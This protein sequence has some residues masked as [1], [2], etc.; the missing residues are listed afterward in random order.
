MSLHPAILIL[1]VLCANIPLESGQWKAEHETYLVEHVRT[2]KCP[3]CWGNTRHVFRVTDRGKNET[4]HLELDWALQELNGLRIFKDRLIV[5][6]RMK[7]DTIVVIDLKARTVLDKIRGY[8]LSFS[9]DSRF[10][11]Y[12]GFLR[13]QHGKNSPYND[14]LL[15]YDFSASPREN[16]IDQPVDEPYRV[17]IPVY[18]RQNL[19]HLSYDDTVPAGVREVGVR[20]PLYWS[21]GSKQIYFVSRLAQKYF[22]VRVNV[23][24]G[25]KMAQIQEQ[26]ITKAEGLEVTIKEI[27]LENDEIV[28]VTFKYGE[29][30]LR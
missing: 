27:R 17:G 25:L 28:L 3:D 15:V 13:P 7:G 21:E 5:H 30:R 1:L 20:S 22:F 8:W 11:V 24:R 10:V 9:P 18:P 26:E 2:E 12:Q 6:G 29:L 4:W 23:G 14:V 19:T 16:R